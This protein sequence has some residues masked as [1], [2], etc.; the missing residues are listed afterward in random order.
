MS[1]RP[2]ST[3]RPLRLRVGHA[4][5]VLTLICFAGLLLRHVQT[6]DLA[7]IGNS[8]RS[9][10][11]LEWTG[12]V[13][14][15][16]ISFFAVG[17]YDVCVHRMLGSGIR[18]RAARHAGM[19]AIALSQTLG[20]GTITGALVRWRCLPE[21]S[22]WGA[23]RVSMLVGLSF[24]GAWAVVTAGALW[25]APAEG[26]VPG[27]L[28][29]GGTAA[30]AALVAGLMIRSQTTPAGGL[31]LSAGHLFRLIGWT[32]LDT[33]AAAVA[34]WML[35]PDGHG[36]GF[37]AL[38]AAYLL[39]LGAGLLSNA[40]GGVGAF[41][42]TLLTL[43]PQIGD[44]ALMGSILAF[45]VV[46]YLGPA[47]IGMAA[48][49]RPTATLDPARLHL[50]PVSLPP[51]DWAPADWGL[52]RQGAVIGTGPG[53]RHGWLLRTLPGFL[54]SIG[55][56]AGDAPLEPV[57]ALARAENLWPLAYKCDGRTAAR[58]RQRGWSVMRIAQDAIIDPMAWHMDGPATRQLRRKLSAAMRAGVTIRQDRWPDMTGLEA[59]H[60]D[61]C[62]LSG[63]ERGFSMG[64]FDRQL[65]AGQ[66]V[67]TAYIG[68]QMIGFVTLHRGGDGWTLDLMRHR[69]GVPAGTMHLLITR[70]LDL[71]R[72]Q[73]I[74]R[75]SLA[76]V[77]DL[78]DWMRGD[79]GLRQFKQAFDP[80]WAARYCAAPNP[81]LLW[82]GLGL[83]TVAVHRPG[84]IDGR[85]HSD[86]R[87]DTSDP[88]LGSDADSVHFGFE[89][90]VPSCDATDQDT[91]C[92]LARVG[93]SRSAKGTD[94][95]HDPAQRPFP[96]A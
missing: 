59:V 41:E 92:A 33:G 3:A 60:R 91:S 79:R 68:D 30:A 29:W 93:A 94:P 83:V 1:H 44:A 31:D 77:P 36:I 26:P 86:R 28:V 75:V 90:P 34:L 46:Y 37:S 49:I 81:V 67:L 76:A 66:L 12:A 73:G 65:V 96:P 38:F 42:L 69:A 19:R 45:R 84:W 50:R 51:P 78:P 32:L 48:L 15:T 6:L 11:A 72:S 62:A 47:V 80:S 18:A 56:P 70:A 64:R 88:V 25:V 9:A 74:G 13:L 53:A 23:T 14:A 8:F 95:D 24:L 39:A 21:L 55:A 40:P 17:Q 85:P 52:V 7:A 16:G 61:W 5:P 82:I 89:S 58:L 43:L 27:L 57:T 2:T 10:S 54:V 20:F 4:V 22:L 35:L 71:A 87:T 63:G